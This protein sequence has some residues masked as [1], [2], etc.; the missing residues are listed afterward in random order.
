M[1]SGVFAIEFWIDRRVVDE[2]VDRAETL[3]NLRDHLAHRIRIGHIDRHC[4]G[5]DAGKCTSHS[6]GARLINVR[7]HNA[8]TRS[9]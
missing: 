9:G 3:Y 8:G 7:H 1:R 4:Q 6:L 2:R 5:R